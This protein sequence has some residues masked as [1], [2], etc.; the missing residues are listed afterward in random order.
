MSWCRTFIPCR[1]RGSRAGSL[2][3]PSR[4]SKRGRRSALSG[5]I[6]EVI[7]A[8]PADVQHQPGAVGVAGS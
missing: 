4:N 8:D 1:R 6:V 3:R 7:G 2:V 5:D